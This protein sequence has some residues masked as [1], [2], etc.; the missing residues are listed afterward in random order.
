VARPIGVC[1]LLPLFLI[2]L[3]LPTSATDNVIPDGD[4]IL[5][6][7]SLTDD[8]EIVV[9]LGRAAKAENFVG[10][11]PPQYL[12]GREAAY[13]LRLELRVKNEQPFVLWTRV[14]TGRPDPQLKGC[15]ALDIAVTP[16]AIVLAVTEGVTV[17]LWRIELMKDSSSRFVVPNRLWAPDFAALLPVSREGVAAKIEQKSSGRT[18]AIIEDLRSG[19]HKKIRFMQTGEAWDFQPEAK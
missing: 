1:A 6:R 16:D 9:V 8:R 15:D 11:L 14:R 2:I 17:V 3:A 19:R 10:V 12:N 18:E 5:L 4:R 7:K 13:Q